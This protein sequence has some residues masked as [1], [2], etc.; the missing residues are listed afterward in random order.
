[1]NYRKVREVYMFKEG[2]LVTAKEYNHY[3][4][5]DRGKPCEVVWYSHSRMRVKCLWDCVEE[6]TVNTA[7]FR[8]MSE[9]EIFKPGQKLIVDMFIGEGHTEIATFMEYKD[10][11]VRVRDSKG[12]YITLSMHSVKGVVKG[13]LYI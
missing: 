6:Y 12:D 3:A 2:Q 9:D 5:T 10:Y 8:P 7:M 13:R 4:V 11:G 1:M